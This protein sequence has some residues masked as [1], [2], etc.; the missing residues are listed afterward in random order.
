V[1]EQLRDA[2]R[3]DGRSL[4]QIGKASGVDAARLSRF[5]RGERDLTLEAADKVCQVLHLRLAPYGPAKPAVAPPQL[6]SRRSE[7][8]AGR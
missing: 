6:A 3:Q 2:I 1:V 7:R 5:M 8:R 4:N